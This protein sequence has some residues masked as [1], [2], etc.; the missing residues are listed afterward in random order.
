MT[1]VFAFRRKD[2]SKY[3]ELYKHGYNH[4]KWRDDKTMDAQ[5][6]ESVK[7]DDVK[8]EVDTMTASKSEKLLYCWYCTEREI[9]CEI[10]IANEADEVSGDVRYVFLCPEQH[11]VIDA[12]VDGGGNCSYD[13]E[14]YELHYLF[15]ILY[16]LYCNH[17]SLVSL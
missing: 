6:Q 2:E 15:V 7:E 10:E 1:A 4:D 16:L 14:T 12:I 17:C 8:S 5:P 13:A 11:Y 9:R 3:C